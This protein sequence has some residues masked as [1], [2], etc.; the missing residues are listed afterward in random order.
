MQIYTFINVFYAGQSNKGI[1]TNPS[2]FQKCV[3]FAS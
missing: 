2:K 3:L 1:G